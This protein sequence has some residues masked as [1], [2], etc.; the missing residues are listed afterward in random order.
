MSAF[1]TEC[2]FLMPKIS[3]QQK[4]ANQLA[5]ENASRERALQNQALIKA[6][7]GIGQIIMTIL[8]LQDIQ[9]DALPFPKR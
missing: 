7:Y 8:G 2:R 4:I 6:T 9:R 1:A 3:M 5:R